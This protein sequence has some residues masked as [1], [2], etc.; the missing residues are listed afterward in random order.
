MVLYAVVLIRGVGVGHDV[1]PSREVPAGK[2]G[3]GL[4][5]GG[6]KKNHGFICW[7]FCPYVY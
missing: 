3:V 6:C 2:L 7:L 5:V 4:G 1:F